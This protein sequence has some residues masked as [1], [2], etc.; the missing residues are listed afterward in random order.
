MCRAYSENW[1]M[2]LLRGCL[3]SLC[4][5]LML[6]PT[7]AEI[8]TSKSVESYYQQYLQLPV[9]STPNGHSYRQTYKRLELYAWKFPS[10]E[11]FARAVAEEIDTM[12]AACDVEPS[13]TNDLK[14]DINYPFAVRERV[15]G[16]L[17]ERLVWLAACH[18]LTRAVDDPQALFMSP[19]E[20]RG[21]PDCGGEYT[22][23]PQRPPYPSTS[24]D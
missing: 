12:L 7:Q 5:T 17:P 1:W 21:V 22:G 6:S 8:R 4:F 11:E 10:E 9:L 20:W 15:R 24:S 3:I 16:K 14:R 13:L 2:S 18:G 23:P 19:E